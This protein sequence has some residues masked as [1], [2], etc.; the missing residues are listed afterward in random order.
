[1]YRVRHPLTE[2]E[3]CWAMTVWGQRTSVQ[4]Q[5]QA[6]G[7]AGREPRGGGIPMWIN[8][9]ARYIPIWGMRGKYRQRTKKLPLLIR[10]YGDR[11][12]RC[13]RICG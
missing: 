12:I 13:P 2:P 6:M 3:S 5:T 4:P 1:M 7:A 8:R 9:F 10:S 11:W